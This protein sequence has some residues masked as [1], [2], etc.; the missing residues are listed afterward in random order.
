ME[1]KIPNKLNEES[2]KLAYNPLT[3]DIY[4][5]QFNRDL[6]QDLLDCISKYGNVSRSLSIRLIWAMCATSDS[7]FMPFI[8]FINAIEYKISDFTKGW[9]KEFA[10]WF[11]PIVDKE[12]S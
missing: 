12:F 11:I 2:F 7:K 9:G 6:T 3:L 8:E 10:D 5:S 4:F 1:L